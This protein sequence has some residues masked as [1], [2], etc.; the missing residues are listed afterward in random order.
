MGIRE[1]IDIISGTDTPS[2]NITEAIDKLTGADTKSKSIADAIS[3][4]DQTEETQPTEPNVDV[5][6][7]SSGK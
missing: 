1:Q 3:K 5:P 6:A 2:A 4:M 7:D